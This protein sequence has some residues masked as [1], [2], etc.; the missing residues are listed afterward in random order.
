M[1]GDHIL[2]MPENSGLLSSASC[3]TS[4]VLIPSQDSSL[5]SKLSD[6]MRRR[7]LNTFHIDN[8]DS[9]ANSSAVNLHLIDVNIYYN[10]EFP[11]ADWYR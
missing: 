3:V 8:S 4:F 1:I 6:V 5:M 11:T 9:Q 7:G 10:E 2:C